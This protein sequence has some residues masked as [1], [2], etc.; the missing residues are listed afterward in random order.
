[1]ETL[2]AFD[3]IYVVS[4]IHMGGRPGFQ[5]FKHVKRLGR[6]AEHLGKVRAGDNVALVLNGDVIDS[7][8]EDIRGY[9]GTQD[10]EPMME[11]IYKTFAPVWK[12]LEKFIREPGRRLV[13][14]TGNHDIEM[15]LPGVE[16]SIRH[17]LTGDDPALNGAI[18][19]ATRGAGY[20]C[21]VGSAR[22][23]CTHG[24]EVDEWNVVDYDALGQLGNA[25]NAGRD[26]EPSRWTPNAGTRLVVDVMNKVK[27]RYP[28]VD[29]LK[30]ETKI[31]VPVLLV[32]APDLAREIDFKS[33][34]GVAWEKVK[35]GFVTRGLLGADDED[36]A[37]VGDEAAA[38]DLAL[39]E[40]LGS[41]MHDLVAGS[42]TGAGSDPDDLLLEAEEVVRGGEAATVDDSGETL[43]WF[44]MAMDRL[45]GVDEVDALRTALLDWLEGDDTFK[46][47]Q[48]DDTFEQIT[49]RVAPS[50]DFIV[51]GH[52]HLERALRVDA[53]T[54]RFYYNC[55]TWIRL[56]Q[57]NERLLND[58]DAFAS[59]VEVLKGGS[60]QALDDAD[61]DGQPLVLDRTATVRIAAE[62]TAVV[63][64]LLRVSDGP[65]KTVKLDVVPDTEFR[66]S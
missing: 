65:R 54:D 37:P 46:V 53:S 13:F 51:T 17:R 45:R 26:I 52:T 10:A 20:A 30:P 5:I 57:F 55:G 23:F 43:G 21:R 44:G 42:G 2:P 60:M 14:V 63:G 62:D 31:V 50:V 58:R 12:G 7:L 24:N 66:K 15:A 47:D 3:E 22:V 32:L 18:T 59:V 56:I 61:V 27:A 1:M 16:R 41:G 25:L 39:D 36:D 28:F 35:G 11:G 29:L 4:D 9:V 48:R 64:Q 33:A 38:A 8:A 19:F 6:L 34:F 49:A 40:L